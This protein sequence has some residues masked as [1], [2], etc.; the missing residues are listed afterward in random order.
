MDTILLWEPFSSWVSICEK[1][2]QNEIKGKA[3]FYSFDGLS[4]YLCSIVSGMIWMTIWKKSRYN[5]SNFIVSGPI[6]VGLIVPFV[7]VV[8]AG[9]I[10]RLP[11][12]GYDPRV[13]VK[14]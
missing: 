5:K 12:S 7:Y 13:L 9:T 2:F 14:P 11:D 3:A 10:A 1:T 8:L 4:F 6:D